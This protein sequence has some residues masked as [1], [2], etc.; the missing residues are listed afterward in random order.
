[1]VSFLHISTIYSHITFIYSLTSLNKIL[2]Q[3][4]RLY[5]HL[6]T[7]AVNINLSSICCYK[8]KLKWNY[9]LFNE[10]LYN[11]IKFP[12]K[13]ALLMNFTSP[14][15]RKLNTLKALSYLFVGYIF[16]YFHIAYKYAAFIE[17]FVHFITFRSFI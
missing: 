9:I 16:T 14:L 7:N 12:S 15:F 5:H 2:F 1:M 13:G 17:A 11:Q 4:S 8:V 3:D 10:K 6:F